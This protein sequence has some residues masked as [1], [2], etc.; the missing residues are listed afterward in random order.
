MRTRENVVFKHK[1]WKDIHRWIGL[2]EFTLFFLLVCYFW[3]SVWCVCVRK[4]KRER[5]RYMNRYGLVITQVSKRLFQKLE[6]CNSCCR[7]TRCNC[8]DDYLVIALPVSIISIMSIT[9]PS[10]GGR[11]VTPLRP[12]SQGS[13]EVM[14]ARRGAHPPPLCECPQLWGP[15]PP[16]PHLFHNTVFTHR[17]CCQTTESKCNLNKWFRKIHSWFH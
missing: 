12:S 1:G 5:E 3:P 7:N 4:R 15:S 10:H 6:K 16:N 13:V 17:L 9:V 14:G 8:H 2:W 11:E